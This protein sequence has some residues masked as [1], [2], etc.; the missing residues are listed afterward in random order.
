[1]NLDPGERRTLPLATVAAVVGLL[2]TLLTIIIGVRIFQRQPVE[3]VEHTADTVQSATK[4]SEG[5]ALFEFRCAPCHGLDGGGTDIAP[6][7]TDRPVMPDD[8]VLRRVRMGSEVMYEFTPED[9]PDDQVSM[10]AE[11]IQTRFIATNIPSLTAEQL[12]QGKTLYREFCTECHG[13]NGTGKSDLG[14]AINRWPPMG[15][16]RIIDGGLLPLP[17]MPRL[18]VNVEELELIAGY[19][20]EMGMSAYRKQ[21][22]EQAS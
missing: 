2:L 5:Q 8:V 6:A 21:Q 1:M 20:Q 7:F 11:Y 22:E 13:V 14:P 18:A 19:V 4:V 3:A 12:E 16:Q 10:I 17:N 9:L 15:I